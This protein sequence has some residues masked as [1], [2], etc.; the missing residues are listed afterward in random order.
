MNDDT[1][2]ALPLNEDAKARLAA[3]SQTVAD[4]V[5]DPPPLQPGGPG[6]TSGGM[7]DLMDAKIAAAEART[8]TKFAQVLARL[9]H[10]PT[11][12]AIWAAAATTI[13]SIVG[14]M[15]AIMAFGSS[16]FGLG[17][18]ASAAAQAGA[19]RAL[20]AYISTHPPAK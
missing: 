5:V 14:I 11:T 19:D 12:G 4:Q 6:G 20:A 18:D 2:R 1:V 15:L 3:L 9:D 8:D 17:M 10:L 16:W 7:S 13:I